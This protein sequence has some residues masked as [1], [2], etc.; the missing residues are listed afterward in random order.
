MACGVEHASQVHGSHPPHLLI[1]CAAGTG[2]QPSTSAAGAVADPEKTLQVRL[3][4]LARALQGVPKPEEGELVAV[5]CATGP[6]SRK[7]DL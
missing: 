5:Q 3:L 6:E 2:A 1:C 4:T 7:L